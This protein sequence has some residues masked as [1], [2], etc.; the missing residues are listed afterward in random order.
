M[1]PSCIPAHLA[2]SVQV[3]RYAMLGRLH[4]ESNALHARSE[5]GLRVQ[6]SHWRQCRGL[7]PRRSGHSPSPCQHRGLKVTSS[8]AR[9]A[10]PRPHS[11]VVQLQWR[12]G[13]GGRT[14]IEKW[15]LAG[16]TE[17]NVHLFSWGHEPAQASS[18]WLKVTSSFARLSVPRPHNTHKETLR[19]A[20]LL[21][22]SC[23]CRSRATCPLDAAEP[24]VQASA[25]W[26]ERERDTCP[27][28]PA[29]YPSITSYKAP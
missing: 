19:W 29:Q 20:Q 27:A 9:L 12:W 15:V 13:G 4:H 21:K 11:H 1:P 8:F 24:A 23:C 7:P 18:P 26:S 28:L 22:N 5:C 3:H 10:V 25:P 17:R 6:G 16:T 2:A 14:Y